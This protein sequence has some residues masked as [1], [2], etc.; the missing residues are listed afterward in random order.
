MRAEPKPSFS[1]T[2]RRADLE[3]IA[4]E[5]GWVTDLE[6]FEFDDEPVELIEETWERTAVRTFW[7]M[8][9]PLY[10]CGVG[11]CDED[12]VAWEQDGGV[13]RQVCEHHRAKA[14]A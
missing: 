2:Y 5:Y 9:E 3:Q 4:D 6:Y 10:S 8:P 11:D 14:G 13:W 12:A 7:R 1:K